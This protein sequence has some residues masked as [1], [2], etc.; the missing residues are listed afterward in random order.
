[1]QRKATLFDAADGLYNW[2][3]MSIVTKILGPD[4]QIAARLKNYESRPQ[5][6]QMAEAVAAAIAQRRH[7]VVEAGTGVG[8]SFAYLVPAIL[9]A[10][11]EAKNDSDDDGPTRRIVISTHTIS[12]QEQLMSK[13]LPLLRSIL[14]RPFSAVLVKGRGNYLSLRRL[15]NAG[16]R[17]VS[18]FHSQREMDQLRD[19]TAW[20]KETKGGSISD[21][22]YRPLP[23][24]WDETASDSGNCMGR[25][26]PTY[27][28]CFYFKARRNVQAAHILVVNHALLFSD[29]ALRRMGV[30]ILPDYHTLIFDEAH[31]VEAVAGDH[32]GLGITSGQVDYILG[33]LYNDRTNKGLLVHRDMGA[34][35]QEV[36]RCRA[37]AADFFGNVNTWLQQQRSGHNGRVHEGGI[38][39]NN[40]SPALKKVAQTVKSQS[41][42]IKNKSEK[43]DFTAAAER[44]KGLA[45]EIEQWNTQAAAD[46]VYWIESTA[47]KARRRPRTRLAAA[48]IDVGP[49][50]KKELLDETPC[51]V[52]TSATLSVGPNRSFEFFQSRIGA[53]QSD[54]LCLGSPFDFRKQ[55]KLVLV[56][57]M[58][59]PAGD[60]EAYER[61]SAAM[62]RRYVARSD[63]HAFALFTSY[64]MMQRVAEDLKP[65]LLEHDLGVYCQA[66]GLPR[67]QMLERF[68]AN[69]RSLL[70]GTVSFW[71]GVDVP[72][73]ALT[74]VIITKLPFSVPDH[75]LLQA[76]LEAIKARGGNP[77]MQY[78]VPEAIIKLRQGFGRLIRSKRDRGMVVILDPRVR[79]KHYGRQ[80][81]QS[82]PECEL[83]VED[84][85]EE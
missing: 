46:Y 18:L 43:Q 44:L 63:G 26:C 45:D 30:Q 17:A 24:V 25:K 19:L 33:K 67:H 61:L 9:A 84:V 2:Q 78:Q 13:D 20:A 50:L 64:S 69:P 11:E 83:V 48:P 55:A 77:F 32:L 37:K 59:D 21:L 57:G 42:G 31:T 1:V 7:L 36:A 38:V 10:T 71:Q 29:L 27:A 39:P 28:K 52:F 74:N 65:W 16:R 49:I 56:R 73:E 76:R 85:A 41:E 72:G 60:R 81:I 62:I 68:K 23:S 6:L 5:Q 75:P 22:D 70:L 58:P 47:A 66:D 34:A 35:Q 80:F 14:D 12:L 40:L 79:T 3:L 51:V 53:G 4:G 54:S 15:E 82:L 8:K